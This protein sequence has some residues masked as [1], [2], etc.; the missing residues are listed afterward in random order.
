MTIRDALPLAAG[1]SLALLAGVGGAVAADK[2]QIGDN[3]KVFPES[4]TAT[5]DGTLYAGSLTLGAIFKAAPGAVKA[6]IW[7]PKPAD[8]PPGIAGV[9]ADEKTGLLWACYVDLATFQGKGA[10]SVLRVIDLKSGEIKASYPFAGPSFCNDIATTADG[11]AYIAD[12]A[13]STIFRIK[14]GATELEAWLKSDQLAGVDGLSFSSDGKLYANSVMANKLM[15]VDIGADGAAG[16]VTDLTLSEPIKGP[17]GMRFGDDGKLYL[18]ENGAGRADEVT[19]DGDKAT[20]KSLKDGLDTP[21]ALSKV[22]S[23]LYVLEAK[24]GLLG[25]TA[26]PGQFYIVPVALQ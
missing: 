25:G 17:D 10:P 18:A 7:V 23:T 19:I 9:Y 13:G 5:S 8:G 12:T 21:T 16:T 4:M 2:V 26:D 11:T 15:R 14:P 24:L 3:Q 20:I 6:D 22:G 1:I